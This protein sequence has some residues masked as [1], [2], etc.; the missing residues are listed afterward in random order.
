MITLINI[1]LYKIFKKWRTYIGFIAIAILT[2][3]VEFA[4]YYEGDRSLNFMT[5]NLQQSFL[6][7]GNLLNCYLISYIL[8]NSLG[9]HIPFLIAL[10]TGDLLAGEATAGTYR[11]VLTRP[12]SRS[13]LI[14]AKF[15][16]GIIY[17]LLLVFWLALLSIGVGYLIF[18]TGELITA[19]GGEIIIFARDDVLWRFFLAYGYAF[20]SMSVVATLA[21]LFSSFVENAIGPIVSTMAIII[22]FLIISGLD[23]NLFKQLKPFLFTSYMSDWKMI[24]KDNIDYYSLIKSSSILI[25]HIILF[26]R[27][28]IYTFNKKDILS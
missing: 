17:T 11:L 26:Y 4:M 2:L 24:F 1:E 23:V 15:I 14:T 9:I 28:A 3:A 16:A 27:T 13:S 5:R 25:A 21:F 8:L 18:G 7:V 20:L 12:V 22:V 6:L 10:V 19:S